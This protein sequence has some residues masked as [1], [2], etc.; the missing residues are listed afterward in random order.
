MSRQEF[1][2][3]YKE[4]QKNYTEVSVSCRYIVI[5]LTVPLRHVIE[6]GE[7]KS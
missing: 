5:D 1:Q 2:K 3:V 6:S 7:V 4:Y